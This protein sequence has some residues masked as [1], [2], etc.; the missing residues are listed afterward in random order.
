MDSCLR[1][2]I[3]DDHAIFRQ[4]L[5]S[6]LRR[7]RDFQ[8]V[9][10]VERAAD[11]PST[12]AANPCDV[13]LL[14]LQMEWS[15]VA[16]IEQLSRVTKVLVLTASERVEDA[17]LALRMG[18]RGIVQKRF[19]IETLMQAIRAVAD[20]QVWMPPE[21]QTEITAQW[22][23]PAEKQLTSREAEI[24][25]YV[26]TG[27]RNAEVAEKLSISENTVKTHLNNIFHKL[28]L[29]DRVEVALYAIRH[30]WITSRSGT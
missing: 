13:L 15:T 18:A 12:V 11:L 5:K 7:N 17:I 24:V 3:A 4:G 8:I 9:G 28:G 26:A 2:T 20:G 30:G 14:D 1:L 23:A 19:A 21:L 27:L 16:D 25:R 22:I 10:E 6:L 29:R